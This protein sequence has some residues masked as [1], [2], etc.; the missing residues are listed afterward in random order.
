MKKRI[1][2]IMLTVISLLVFTNKVEAVAMYMECKYDQT[3]YDMEDGFCTNEMWSD[4]CVPEINTYIPFTNNKGNIEYKVVKIKKDSLYSYELED[5]KGQN[6]CW[7]KQ[8]NSGYS[9]KDSAQVYETGPIGVFENGT[10]PNGI[11]LQRGFQPERLGHLADCFATMGTGGWSIIMSFVN[12]RSCYNAFCDWEQNIEGWQFIPYGSSG[13]KGEHSQIDKSEYVFY[14]FVNR[15]GE[16]QIIGEGYN[17]EG[18]Y[19]YIGPNIKNWWK[20]E[21]TAYQTN[22]ILELRSEYW[23]VHNN[24]E[25]RLVA[26]KGKD[27]QVGNVNVC[28]DGESDC[29]KNHGYKTILTSSDTTKLEAPLKDWY[30]DNEERLKEYHDIVE[31]ANKEVFVTTSEELNNTLFEG[32]TYIFNKT[33]SNGKK[34]D[35]EALITDLEA[36]YSALEKAYSTETSTLDYGYLAL[37]KEVPTSPGSSATSWVY[38]KVLGINETM[39]IALEEDNEFYLNSPYIV[40]A[41]KRDVEN[42]LEK[43]I[44]GLGNYKL[45]LLDVTEKL[46]EYTELFYTTAMYLKSNQLIFNLTPEQIDRLSDEKNQDGIIQKF[47]ALIKENEL[48]IY[49][50]VDCE[51]LLGEDLIEKIKSYTNIIKIAVPI[52]LIGFGIIDFT[53]AMFSGDEDSM[54]KSQKNFTRRLVVALLI[55]LTPTIVELILSLANKVWLT[56]SPDSCGIF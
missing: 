52:I 48:D 2:L 46:N 44:Q 21:I 51:S 28:K 45:N 37:G 35:A 43:F 10:C 5:D 6:G 16:E 55:F 7:L 12:I 56:I 34:Y 49:P 8:Y 31:L 13:S 11:I 41:L 26:Y 29:T 33:D 4:F 9:C 36:V 3:C 32:K 15:D 18:R 25:S 23:K 27:S 42:E 22:K 19:S 24:F 47:A 1:I 39:D 53:K 54:K 14:S 40:Q 38:T 17:V 20:D 30:A 50:I